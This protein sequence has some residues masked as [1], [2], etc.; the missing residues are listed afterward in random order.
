MLWQ[1][2]G[3]LAAAEAPRVPLPRAVLGDY[4]SELRGPDGRVDV[5]ATLGRLKALGANTYFWLVWH[6]ATDWEDLKRFL[7]KA[8][9]AGIDVWAYLAP[10]SESPPNTTLYS[11]PFRLDYDRWAEEIAGLSREHPNLKAWVIDDF[12]AN[13]D[14]FTP[15]RLAQMRERTRRVN[16]K[17]AFLPL[18]YF[19][20]ITPGFVRQ[21][22]KVVDGVVVA[23]PRDRWEVEQARRLLNGELL[24]VPN[25]FDY[26]GATP[27]TPGDFVAAAQTATVMPAGPYAL[28]FREWDNFPGPT[29]GYHFKQLLVD[30]AVVWEEDVAGGTTRWKDVAVDVTRQ[31]KGKRSVSVAFRLLDKRG[32]SQFALRWTVRDLR[33]KG[34]ALRA[35]LDQ[36]T[37]WSVTRRGAFTA[38]FGAPP[39]KPAV[40]PRPIPFIVMT[41]AEEG[42]FRG[43]HG[44]PA[45][46]E[47]IAS[48]LRMCL[49][50]RRDGK[51]DGVVTYCLDKSRTSKVFPHA[52]R[53]FREFARSWRNP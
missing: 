35:G 4:D 45:S 36:P 12:Y 53:V 7:P 18:M 38:G 37:Q 51:C 14:F 39:A 22:S 29:A 1:A 26:P 27:S 49:Q 43:R 2:R 50:A 15:E 13:H 25:A 21:Y 20:E 40:K 42:E 5:D 17:L 44:D 11:E 48:W 32:V 31:V 19:F 8:A 23:Y 28:R 9:E 41:A 10:P 46:P 24:I 16:P 52:Q 30:D 34:L 6:A 33:A 3:A 47:R